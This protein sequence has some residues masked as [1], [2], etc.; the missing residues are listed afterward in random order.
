MRSR[1]KKTKDYE[2]FGKEVTLPS[3]QRIEGCEQA[4]FLKV[5]EAHKPEY[6]WVVFWRDQ[7][8]LERA[9]TTPVWREQMRKFEAGRFCKTLPLQMVCE[10]LSSFSGAPEP[11]PKKAAR[12][13]RKRRKSGR[14][15]GE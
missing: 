4:Y 3:L 12:P 7:K 14:T 5:F 9:R 2:A 13:T 11:A 15:R 6:F 10:C 8:A 1:K